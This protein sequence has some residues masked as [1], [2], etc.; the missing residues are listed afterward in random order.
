VDDVAG[1]RAA[2]QGG[3]GL[4]SLGRWQVRGQLVAERDNLRLRKSAN[5]LAPA[6]TIAKRTD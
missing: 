3:Q 5:R 6:A 1:P 2:A 4:T